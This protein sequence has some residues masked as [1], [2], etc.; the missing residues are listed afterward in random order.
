MSQKFTCIEFNHSTQNSL[1]KE[2]KR[3]GIELTYRTTN[4]VRNFLSSKKPVT[5]K[6]NKTGIYKINCADCESAYIG[7]TG[8]SFKIRHKEHI[9]DARVEKQKSAFAQHLIDHK[10][11]MND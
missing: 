6:C 5:D 7:Q 10:H 9:P 11:S 3:H 4:R 2:L 1:Q 8:R